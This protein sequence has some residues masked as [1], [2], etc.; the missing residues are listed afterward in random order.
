MT[1]PI[2]L[3]VV[4]DDPLVRTGLRIL[5]G[6]SPDIELVAEA[7]DGTEVDRLADAHWPDVVLM[8][9]R[10][11]KVDGLVATR[12]LR[13]RRSPPHVIVLT[14]F[15]ADEHVLDAL[16]AGA[17]GFLL[18]DT[19]PLDI[20][21]AVRT[22]AAGSATL[23]PAVIRQLIDHVADPAAGPRRQQARGRL[24][25]LTDREREVAVALGRGWSNAEIAAGLSM[26]VP[27]V[28][29]HVSRLLTKLDLNNRVQ[30]AL[31][32]HDAELL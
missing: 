13:A 30:V 4:D 31:L 5:L 25:R 2:R 29:G 1:R 17:S 15:N 3:A 9:I 12:R 26:S 24:A 21:A 7:K 6:G 10:M 23:S 18:K 28:K 8:D 27:T 19:P 22:V 11:P 16:R 20:I 32:V 14:T